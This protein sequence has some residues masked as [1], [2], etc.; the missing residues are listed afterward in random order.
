MCNNFLGSTF[1]NKEDET[2][3]ETIVS[4]AVSAVVSIVGLEPTQ[5]SIP[6]ES[7]PDTRSNMV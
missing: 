3:G 1:D 5:T 4:P 7:E 6:K 2:A